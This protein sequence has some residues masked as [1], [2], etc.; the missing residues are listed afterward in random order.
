MKKIQIIAIAFSFIVMLFVSPSIYGQMGMQNPGQKMHKSDFHKGDFKKMMFEK[1]NLTDEQKDAVEKLKLKHQSEMIDLKA[2]LEKKELAMKELKNSGNYSREEFVSTVKSISTAKNNIAISM[3]NHR[4]DV[5][6]LLTPEQKKTFDNM[7][8][9]FE[10]R[11][12]MMKHM[13]EKFDK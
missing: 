12:P 6:E 2:D 9:M 4:M 5:Y 11:M 13:K 10:G 3:A 1:L 7:N 8:P